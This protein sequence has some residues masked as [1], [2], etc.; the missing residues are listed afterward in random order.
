MLKRNQVLLNTLKVAKLPNRSLFF[1]FMNFR[2]CLYIFCICSL[3]NIFFFFFFLNVDK[4]SSG[5]LVLEDGFQLKC[6]TFHLV[7]PIRDL[8]LCLCFQEES[9]YEGEEVQYT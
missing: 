3:I 4:F 5:I 2:G 8:T 9:D 7:G 6:L 1:S